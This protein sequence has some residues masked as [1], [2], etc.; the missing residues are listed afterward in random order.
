MWYQDTGKPE[1]T[2]RKKGM[3]RHH[4]MPCAFMDLHTR[5]AAEITASGKPGQAL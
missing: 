1:V 2:A 5:H 3:W 4:H